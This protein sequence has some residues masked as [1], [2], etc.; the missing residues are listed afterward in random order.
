MST[1]RLERIM[2]AREYQ[3][4]AI[5]ALIPEQMQGHVEVIEKEVKAIVR[6]EFFQM[7]QSEEAR[8]F[9]HS[10]MSMENETE[11]KTNEKKT[12]SKVKKVTIS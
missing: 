4:K 5:M 1:E 12:E 11:E 3:K 9:I 6:E 8:K 2:K 10:I 7:L